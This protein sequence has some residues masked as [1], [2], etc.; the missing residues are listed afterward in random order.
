MKISKIIA[1]G[2]LTSVGLVSNLQARDS[3]GVCT[4]NGSGDIP[5]FFISHRVNIQTALNV[6]NH[7]DSTINV[8]LM[9]FDKNG[10][11]RTDHYYPGG[12]SSVT[13][14]PRMSDRLQ[15]AIR[16]APGE[17]LWGMVKWASDDCVNK[18]MIGNLERV[19][20]GTADFTHLAAGKRF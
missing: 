11:D 18:P 2:A 16:T 4:D 8:E 13:L 9:L 12:S 5:P 6:S 7:S 19:R 1:I 20:S 14:G 3:G 10:D 15:T 17:T